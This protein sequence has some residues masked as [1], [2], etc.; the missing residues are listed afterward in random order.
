MHILHFSLPSPMLL[1]SQH[2]PCVHLTQHCVS[3]RFLN[4]CLVSHYLESYSCWIQNSSVVACVL[5]QGFPL[6]TVTPLQWSSSLINFSEL[7]YIKYLEYLSLQ[8]SSDLKLVIHYLSKCLFCSCLSFRKSNYI[9]LGHLEFP[10]NSQMLFL[11]K[12]N[13]TTMTKKQFLFLYVFH[14][15]LFLCF[16]LTVIQIFFCN[17]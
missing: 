1:W 2:P 14:S 12:T 15:E 6:V 4:S 10:H 9:I 8:F 13:K 7:S 3:S 17:V 16:I 11:L 5:T